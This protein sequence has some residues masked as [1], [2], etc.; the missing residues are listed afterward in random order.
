MEERTASR[1][2]E[3]L[4]ARDFE[5]LTGTLSADARA[6]M[7]LPRGLEEH[8]GRE[9]VVAR[10]ESWFGAA[11]EFDLVS[12]SH[13]SVGPR[14]RLSWR[15]DL[16]RG[17]GSRELVEQ[18]AYLDLGA[19]GIRRIDLLCSGFHPQDAAGTMHEFD[20]GDMGCADG[21]AQEFR[22]QITCVPIGDSLEVIT[23]DPAAK[24]DLPSLARMLGHAVT[25]I[26]ALGDG[27]LAITVEVR[28]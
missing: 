15:F 2:L 11:S 18:V 5:R 17:G 22:R 3:H 24:E 7:L 16:V 9:A 10:I 19:D 20:A 6:R 23:S 8:S 21:L 12:S 1:F 13:E 14:H 28:R 26:E 25:S 27:R 4:A